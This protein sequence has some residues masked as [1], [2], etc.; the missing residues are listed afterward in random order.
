MD[1]FLKWFVVSGLGC[2]E[3]DERVLKIGG[4]KRIS[5][6]GGLGGNGVY[7]SFSDG[8]EKLL[9][10]VMNLSSECEQGC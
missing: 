5:F 9:E 10:V 3:V 6:F 8:Q 4:K 2:W 1:K 7:K